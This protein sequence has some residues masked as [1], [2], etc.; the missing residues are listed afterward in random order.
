MCKK[1]AC[2][3]LS[4]LFLVLGTVSAA[5]IDSRQADHSGGTPT[6]LSYTNYT[7][8]GLRISSGGVATCASMLQ[9]YPGITTKVS[10]EMTLQKRFLLLFWTT[11]Q[12]WSQTFTGDYG[13]LEKTQSVSGGTYRVSATFMAYSGTNSEKVT[14]TSPTADY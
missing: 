8:T 13:A 7:Y 5:A 14:A 2:I 6:R 12:T 3:L 11:E 9:G 4:A 10:I 1:L